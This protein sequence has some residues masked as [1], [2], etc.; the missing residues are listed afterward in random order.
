[1]YL[2]LFLI[3]LLCFVIV[4]LITHYK[5]S[6]T[7]FQDKIEVLENILMELNANL[8]NQKQK[9]KLSEDLQLKIKSVN[10]TLSNEIL[11]LNTHFLK[12]LYTKKSS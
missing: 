3:F 1:M 4:A 2:A 9:V 7:I 11:D 5:R 8:E 10:H 6:E 12:N